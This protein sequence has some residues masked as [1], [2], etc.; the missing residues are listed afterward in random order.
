MV[1]WRSLL[2]PVLAGAFRARYQDSETALILSSDNLAEET[3]FEQPAD[4]RN[5]QFV[6]NPNA[7]FEAAIAKA[8]EMG[9]SVAMVLADHTGTVL[10]VETTEG[11][12]GYRNFAAGKIQALI[13]NDLDNSRLCGRRLCVPGAIASYAV[14]G[15]AGIQ[16]AVM[17][18]YFQPGEGQ[19]TGFFSV[20]GCPD[21][22]N[23]VLIAKFGLDGA[24][25]T[26]VVGETD[27]YGFGVGH[28]ANQIA[29]SAGFQGSLIE[30][31]MNDNLAEEKRLGQPSDT[32]NIRYVR[33]PNAIFEAA[34]AK[35]TEM[36]QGVAMVL[37]DS[38]GT[39]LR[40]TTTEGGN[41]YR[42]FAA[43]KIQAL[44]HNDLDN[45]RLCSRRLCVPGAIA[46]YAVTGRAGVQGAVMFRYF[47]PGQGQVTGFFSVSGCPDMWDDV[48]IAKAGLESAGYTLLNG[49]TDVYGFGVVHEANQL[50]DG[51]QGSR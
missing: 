7:I 21:M 36:G 17:F 27:V 39:T 13:H 45:S 48:L 41:G 4:T 5:I 2:L 34:I 40:I 23:D 35:A 19:V 31:S 46:N 22:W 26:L 16:G 49:E 42:N 8:T 18:R 20:S 28:Q 15:R 1:M 47:Q 33:N 11:G 32:R 51:F 9:E 24:G 43:G 44:I 10:R 25:Y 3:M 30:T 37:A 12:S 14:T 38:A 6:R 29:N 50:T